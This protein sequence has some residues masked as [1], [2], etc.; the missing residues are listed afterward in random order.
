MGNVNGIKLDSEFKGLLPPLTPE[1]YEGLEQSL[2]TE[3][4]RDPLVLWQGTLIDGYNRYELCQKH[5]IEFQ[6]VSREL[7]SRED[8]K[9]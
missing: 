6:T 7:E 1:E 8:V 2:I 9:V 4:C 5:G 3:G